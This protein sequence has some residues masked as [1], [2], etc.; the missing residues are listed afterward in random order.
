MS[1]KSM[2]RLLLFLFFLSGVSALIYQ[3]VW[4][5]MF[6][7]VFG[8]TVYAVA[9][10]VT[11]FMAGLALGAYLFGRWIDRA[12]NPLGVF[13]LLQLGIGLFALLF[14]SLLG[15]LTQAYVA[16]HRQFPASFYMRSL[17]RFGLSFGLLILPTTLMGGTLPVLS[18]FFVGRLKR[19]GGDM[20]HLYAANNLGAV[21]GVFAAGFFLIRTVG[22]HFTIGTAAAINLAVAALAYVASVKADRSQPSPQASE[23][24]PDDQNG[25]APPVAAPTYP[26]HV[27]TLVLWAFGIEGF[28]ALSYEVVWTRVLTGMS[29]HKTVYLFST[30]LISFIFGLSLGS[31]IIARFIDRTRSLLALFGLMEIAI[32]VSAIAMLPV[33]KLLPG[34]LRQTYRASLEAWWSGALE[35]LIWFLVLLVPTTLMGTTF[36]IVS[37]IYTRTLDALGRRIGTIG[38]LDTIGSIFGSFVA[39]F[40]LIPFIGMAKAVAVTAVINLLIGASLVAFEPLR[41]G[42]L[43]LAAGVGG[44]VLAVGALGL[45]PSELRFEHWLRERP[46]TH[47]VYYREGVSATVAVPELPSGERG[48]MIDGFTTAVGNYGDLRVHKMLGY[49]PWLLHENPKSSLVIG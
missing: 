3:V 9:T 8:V 18:K 45:T 24:G 12:G 38:C 20:G 27:R 36:P 4:V 37:K 7:D 13:A 30:I 42:K 17:V 48:L 5:R 10:V 21:I 35:N 46:F 6:G 33:F 34:L 29:H 47:F 19:L 16:L 15:R 41:S 40:V 26:R 14:P 2:R 22:M 49:L 32:G 23:E 39:G 28:C 25:D 43:K 31:F 44:V 1:E 11:T